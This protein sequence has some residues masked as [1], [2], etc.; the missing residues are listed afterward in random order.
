MTPAFLVGTTDLG[1]QVG[2]GETGEAGDTA[3]LG[4]E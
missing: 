3:S 4:G 1:W 2:V